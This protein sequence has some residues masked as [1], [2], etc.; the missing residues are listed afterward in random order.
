[1]ANIKDVAKRAEVS[2]TTASFVLS[3][4]AAEFRISETAA[5]RVMEAAD[6]LDYRPNYHARTFKRG[7]SDVLGFRSSCRIPTDILS[8]FGKACSPASTSG[9]AKINAMC[10]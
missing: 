1:M 10:S 6:A 4:K 5:Q 9:R 2:V 3:G 8:A 7:R